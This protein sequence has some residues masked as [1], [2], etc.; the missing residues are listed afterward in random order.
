MRIGPGGG[1]ALLLLLVAACIPAPPERG[2]PSGIDAG[3]ADAHA[4][5]STGAV[6]AD[7][8]GADAGADAAHSVQDASIPRDADHDAPDAA[9]VHGALDTTFGSQGY[10]VV[11]DPIATMKV[12]PWGLALVPPTAGAQAGKILAAGSVTRGEA[13]DA[14]VARFTPEGELDPSFQGG[15]AVAHVADVSG[16]FDALAVDTHGRV[17]VAGW[18]MM[19]PE[20]P[21]GVVL[22]LTSDG[23]RDASF[24]HDGVV[25][26]A[27][28][29]GALVPELILAVAVLAN[30]DL[31]AVG[32]FRE[33]ATGRQSAGIVKIRAIDGAIDPSFGGGPRVFPVVGVAGRESSAAT[34]VA[35]DAAG[36]ILVAGAGKCDNHLYFAYN[37]CAPFVARFTAGGA[38][39]PTFGSVTGGTG[40]RSG[41]AIARSEFGRFNGVAVDAAGRIVAVGGLTGTTGGQFLVGRFDPANGNADLDFGTDGVALIDAAF[42][43]SSPEQ[44]GFNVVAEADG[45]LTIT[46]LVRLERAPGALSAA[47]GLVRLDPKGAL[48]RSFGSPAP[49]LIDVPLVDSLQGIGAGLLHGADGKLLMLATSPRP[50]DHADMAV[51]RFSP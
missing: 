16:A 7:A 12:V 42:D 38:L 44:R 13:A 27:R 46:G 17:I 2:E 39:D 47:T 36:R 26:L 40:P 37:E 21:S 19:Q 14:I 22:R 8:A 3:V 50:G 5:V 30:D 9:A 10:A 51:L 25:D 20:Y 33:A 32:R 18:A 41:V 23:V 31:V 11:H 29:A 48:D 1:A 4:D 28:G 15:R 43:T 35:L 45:A 24:G 6:G 49:V 34:G